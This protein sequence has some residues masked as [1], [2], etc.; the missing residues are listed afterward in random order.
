MRHQKRLFQ[1]AFALL[2]N[3]AIREAASFLDFFAQSNFLFL[4]P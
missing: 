3:G 1:K 4:V 2:F